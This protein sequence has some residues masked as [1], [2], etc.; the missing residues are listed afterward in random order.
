[1]TSAKSGYLEQ[2]VSNKQTRI[3]Y[4]DL[5]R[6]IATFA[7]IGIHSVSEILDVYRDFISPFDTCVLVVFR[8]MSMIGVPTFVLITGALFLN[9][10]KTIN[11]SLILK[12]YVPRLLLALF[13][14]G[15]PFAWIEI[16]FNTKQVNLLQIFEAFA[17]VLSG[18][19]WAHL[20][21]L[22]MIIGIYLLIPLFKVFTDRARKADLE[23]LLVILF[24]FN[25][26][27]TW[28]SELFC[29][30]IGFYV[31]INSVFPFYLFLGHYLS[32]Y[33]V[34][35]N[36][37]IAFAFFIIPAILMFVYAFGHF[38]WSNHN[39]VFAHYS[40]FMAMMI[41][42]IFMLAKGNFDPN[43]ETSQ[44]ENEACRIYTCR[45]LFRK[46]IMHISKYCFGIYLIHN[47][48]I[49]LIY[50]GAKI[51]P[52]YYPNYTLFI[53][54]VIMLIVPILS[55][56]FSVAFMKIPKLGKIIK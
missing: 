44:N 11:Y 52:N 25:I 38:A 48:F 46:V 29:L 53:S 19:S 18:N 2:N 43:R 15:V 56:I 50:K 45:I 47:L 10:N 39:V 8:S 14:F 28:I 42:G 17:R 20:W 13:A 51:T 27:F 31:P 34:K 36:K 55:Y 7:V 21:Y 23:V 24:A 5:L 3:Y 33:E 4:F 22:Y 30:E 32:Q 41:A 6:V 26:L 37:K 12:K 1:M 49:N 9:Q 35:N 16:I 40:P 54:L